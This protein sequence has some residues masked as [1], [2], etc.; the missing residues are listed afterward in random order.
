VPCV[1]LRENTERPETIEVGS[2]VLAGTGASE[3]LA[4]VQQMLSRTGGWQNPY[5]DGMAGR[6]IVMVCNGLPSQSSHIS[7]A[8]ERERDRSR[9]RT[10]AWEES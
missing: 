4:S 2:N 3:I 10:P 8:R 7:H 9:N 6:M 1:T 5:G